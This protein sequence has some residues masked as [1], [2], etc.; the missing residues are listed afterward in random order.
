MKRATCVVVVLLCVSGCRQP[1]AEP[2]TG[3]AESQAAAEQPGRSVTGWASDAWQG[4]VSGGSQTVGNT[5]QWL[6]DLYEAARDQ[7]LTTASSVK[8][9]VADDWKAQGDWQYRILS[10]PAGDREAVEAKLN[11]AGADRWEC[12]H[13]D[14]SGPHWTFFMKRTRRSYLSRIPLK[15]LTN[16]VPLLSGEPP[17]GDGQ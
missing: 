11:E 15:D 10:L 16:L 2:V 6:T 17:A 14:T 3:S 4:A 1:V 12:Y 13:V 9:W 5:G 7:G 8:E